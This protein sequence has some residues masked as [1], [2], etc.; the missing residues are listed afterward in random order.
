MTRLLFPQNR[1]AYLYTGPGDPIR[2]P[3]T[4]ALTVYLDAACTTLADITDLSGNPLPGSLVFIGSDGLYPQFYGPDGVRV[5][6]IKPPVDPAIMIEADYNGRI[7]DLENTVTQLQTLLQT[8]VQTYCFSLD[9]TLAVAPGTVHLNNDTSMT[10]QIT[11]VRANVGTAPVGADVIID[12]NIDGVSIFPDTAHQLVIPDGQTTSGKHV[13][14]A[15]VAPGSALSVDIDQVGTTTAGDDL[16]V[17]LVV[18]EI[19]AA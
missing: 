13:I 5:L 12:V 6:Y 1:T 19:A 11:S 10:W 16:L 4:T 9:N 17:E 8:R 14:T 2:Q 3:W 15:N 7:T 18:S